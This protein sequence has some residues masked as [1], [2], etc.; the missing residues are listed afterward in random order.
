MNINF[1][2]LYKPVMLKQIFRIAALLAIMLLL[3]ISNFTQVQAQQTEKKT[4]TI[5]AIQL[6]A[7][8]NPPLAKFEPL[9]DIGDAI[10]YTEDTGTGLTRVLLGDYDNRLDAET[11]LARVKISGSKQAI[12]KK[13]VQEY[14]VLIPESTPQPAPQPKPQPQPQ[15]QKV[16]PTPDNAHSTTQKPQ[17]VPTPAPPLQPTYTPPSNTTSTSPNG[18]Q[19]V[20]Q[21]GAFARIDFASFGN[22]VDLGQLYSEREGN[23]VKV[24]LGVFNT[25]AEAQ[26]ALNIMRTRGYEYVYIRTVFDGKYNQ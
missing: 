15:P 8:G 11:A 13:I 6:G 19:Y 18:M 25:E 7:F 2:P 23:L 17:P 12:I 3:V 21:L 26:R 14:E 4:R 16:I 5:Y 9:S 20:I 22:I 1:K 24:V 10:I